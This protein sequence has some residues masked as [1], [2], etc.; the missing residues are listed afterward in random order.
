MLDGPNVIQTS[1]QVETA[2]H[3]ILFQSLLVKF[4][5]N[6]NISKVAISIAIQTNMVSINLKYNQYFMLC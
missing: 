5:E 1:C 4:Y 6:H 3:I 2:K